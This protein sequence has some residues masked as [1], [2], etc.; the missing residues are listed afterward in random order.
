M[1][2]DNW[3]RLEL[4]KAVPV[5]ADVLAYLRMAGVNLDNGSDDS[6]LG[7]AGA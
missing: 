1:Y 2:A 5:S 3:L 4:P 6:T 7:Q